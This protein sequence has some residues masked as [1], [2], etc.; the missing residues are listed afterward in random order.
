MKW[1]PIEIVNYIL[2]YSDI[3]IFMIY[4]KKFKKHFMRIDINHPKFS[5]LQNMY[6]GMELSGGLHLDTDNERNT[7]VY[8]PIPLRKIPSVTN[9]LNNV[10][11]VDQYM[12]IT[13]MEKEHEVVKEHT[14]STVIQTNQSV[15]MLN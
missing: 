3:G 14:T 15:L 13:I 2:E 8:Y 11:S 12:S 6:G 4:S 7:Q 5:G 10:N 9:R 1:L